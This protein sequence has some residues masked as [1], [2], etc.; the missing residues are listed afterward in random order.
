MN[1]ASVHRDAWL[2]FAQLC[3]PVILLMFVLGIA[4]GV[5]QT[6]TQLRDSSLPFI[7]KVIGVAVLSTFAGP[8]MMAGVE[9]YATRLLLAIPRLLHG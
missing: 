8:F 7:V 4:I 2:A 1:A 3:G 5:L 6:A 9:Q